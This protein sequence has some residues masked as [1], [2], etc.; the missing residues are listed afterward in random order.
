MSCCWLGCWK[1]TAHSLLGTWGRLEQ[2]GWQDETTVNKAALVLLCDMSR[3][4][5]LCV[6]AIHLMVAPPP[7]L[8]SL[9]SD[10]L[11]RCHGHTHTHTSM[12]TC[13]SLTS[14]LY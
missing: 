6:S 3:M 10:P 9:I 4:Q 1:Q 2:W 11:T 8:M 5:Q 7:S 14:F 13:M 12:P